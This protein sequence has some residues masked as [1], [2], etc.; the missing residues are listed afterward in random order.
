MSGTLT[1]DGTSG[2]TSISTS[3]MLT[4]DTTVGLGFYAVY[5]I[6][7]GGGAGA[8]VSNFGGEGVGGFDTGGNGG[9]WI[10]VIRYAGD[11]TGISGE[12]NTTNGGDSITTFTASGTFGID[13]STRQLGATLRGWDGQRHFP[14]RSIC[15]EQPNSWL[16]LP[17]EGKLLTRTLLEQQKKTPK[18]WPMWRILPSAQTGFSTRRSGAQCLSLH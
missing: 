7:G 10:V 18:R 4:G 2:A 12:S 5:L 14:K 1:L 16:R 13:L 15:R 3:Y 17:F 8:V 6:V 11:T 9:S